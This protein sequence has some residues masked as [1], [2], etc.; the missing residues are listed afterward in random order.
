MRPSFARSAAIL[1]SESSQSDI[2]EVSTPKRNTAFDW[3]TG[4]IRPAL[5]LAVAA[6]TGTAAA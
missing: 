4:F 2:A 1:S 6:A 5:L 3:M